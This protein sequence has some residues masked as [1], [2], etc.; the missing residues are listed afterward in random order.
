[1]APSQRGLQLI[2]RQHALKLWQEWQAHSNTSQHA[3]QRLLSTVN[4]NQLF[5]TCCDNV[6]LGRVSLF[7]FM[8]IQRVNSR[9]Q[10]SKSKY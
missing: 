4:L 9:W 7:A 5:K 1:M 10:Q 8:V 3:H 2:V 6:I